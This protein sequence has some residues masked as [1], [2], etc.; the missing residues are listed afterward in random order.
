M[1]KISYCL[2]TAVAPLHL[3]CTNWSPTLLSELCSNSSPFE[4]QLFSSPM[5]P[6]T[7]SWWWGGPPCSSLS[8]LNYSPFSPL[9]E[10]P[11][12]RSHASR[13]CQKVPSPRCN[14]S[15][16]PRASPL[17]PLGLLLSPIPLLSL[18]LHFNICNNYPPNILAFT[19]SLPTILCTILPPTHS[20][21]LF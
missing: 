6:M 19:S 4:W 20:L 15:K 9:P 11:S 18:F 10:I 2:H 21:E 13:Q 1:S 7:R 5:S 16:T 17:I 14:H 3:P 12:F 8:F